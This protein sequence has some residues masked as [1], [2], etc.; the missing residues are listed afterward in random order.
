M[1]RIA[2][3]ALLLCLLLSSCASGGNDLN[4]Y[5]T[6]PSK[7]Q[8]PSDNMDASALTPTDETLGEIPEESRVYV[9]DYTYEDSA[10]G[11][12]TVT[13]R[14]MNSFSVS[15]DW[16]YYIKVVSQPVKCNRLMR[17]NLKTGEISSP[18]LDPVCTHTTSS[19]PFQF[20]YIGDVRAHGRY[21][22]FAG[23]A[24][25]T[26]SDRIHIYDTETGKVH[27]NVFGGSTGGAGSMYSGCIGDDVYGT[28]INKT[29]NPNSTGS[30]DRTIYDVRVLKYNIP[31]GKLTEVHSVTS[32][33][34]V[35]GLAL[36][37]NGRYFC[38][39]YL[40][41]SDMETVI[42]S[43]LPDGSDVREHKYFKTVPFYVGDIMF[44]NSG[45]GV[46]TV[47]MT[48]GDSEKVV[49]DRGSMT[50]FTVTNKYIYYYYVIPGED[51]EP[52]TYQLWRCDHTGENPQELKAPERVL[53]VDFLVNGKYLYSY[54]A[55]ADD[56]AAHVARLD[57]ETGEILYID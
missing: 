53:G 11:M 2:C 6:D 40:P 38:S 12:D 56:N 49:R 14:T 3:L 7:I 39:D 25:G 5:T 19:C 45:G 57:L 36:V 51:N 4:I 31:T 9:P 30:N 15:G 50:R 20:S 54:I 22:I 41:G 47:N 26:T 48:T 13:Q 28:V 46:Q 27:Q 52:N 34:N 23:G 17:L 21:I 1:K 29:D 18:C 55:K 10:D 37:H 33:K 44:T 8:A 42:S 43:R 16:L 24:S 32:T 35:G